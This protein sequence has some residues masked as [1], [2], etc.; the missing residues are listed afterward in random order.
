[1]W[2]CNWCGACLFG[3]SKFLRIL[4][5]EQRFS[6]T[7]NS[8]ITNSIFRIVL[9]LAYCLLS[10]INLWVYETPMH[11]S[12]LG[13]NFKLLL[14]LLHQ[15]LKE[16][17]TNFVSYQLGIMIYKLACKISLNFLGSFHLCHKR[18]VIVSKWFHLHLSL[19]YHK[20]QRN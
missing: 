20:L 7:F 15:I 14:K 8:C 13:N 12:G 17:M 3:W 19:C 11:R 18:R 10:T 1:M 4:N 2:C 5:K 6:M 9:L 16:L